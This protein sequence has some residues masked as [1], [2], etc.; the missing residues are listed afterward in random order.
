MTLFDG[1]TG[2]TIAVV[3]ATPITAIRTAAAS[4]LATRE[5]AREDARVL[6]IVG[7]V[8]GQG[9]PRSGCSPQSCRSTHCIAAN[10][11]EAE[12]LRRAAPAHGRS[13]PRGAAG[14]RRRITTRRAPS[15][16]V[17]R[18][19]WLR[20]SPHQRGR[21]V[22]PAHPRAGL[23]NRPRLDVRRRQ[24]RVC[25]ERVGRL[26]P[27]ARRGRDRRG[28]H[29]S[30]AGRR[31]RGRRTQGE[32]RPRRSRCSSRW[33]S[34]PKTSS[35][36]STSFD[37]RARPAAASPPTFDSD[38]RDLPGGGRDRRRGSV[39]AAGACATAGRSVR[40]LA[41]ARRLAAGRRFQD[42]RSV[43]CHRASP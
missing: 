14:G 36:P 33:E 31:P 41:Q 2:Q 25:R 17:L 20:R 15:E 27:G 1:E 32:R 24:P 37:G 12:V 5:L 38:R 19:E 23:R 7:T 16:P 18:R 9:A 3:N 11:R 34:Q 8:S 28:P 29:R 4:A 39:H 35:R 40:A 21:R 22:L 13:R 43:E 30:G 10:P 26:P 6:A 42:S